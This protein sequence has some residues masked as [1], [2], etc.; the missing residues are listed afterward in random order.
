MDQERFL[1]ACEQIVGHASERDVIGRL[2]E[3]TLH[4]VIKQYVESDHTFHEVKLGAYYADVLRN[5]HVTEIQTRSLG[6]L[7]EKLAFF[8]KEHTVT[9]IYPIPAEKHLIW[10]DAETGET[11]EKRK[12]SKR[13]SFYDAGRELWY[14][15]ELLGH[16]R[17]TVHLMLIDM[18][19][20]RTR[21]KEKNKRR[22]SVRYDRIPLALREE[23]CLSTPSSYTA[24]LPDVL[25]G[26]F[27]AKDFRRV[28]K[29]GPKTAPA[30]LSVLLR[31][32]IVERTGKA[33]RAYLYKRAV[34]EDR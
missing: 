16:P 28:V 3:K 27:T 25:N 2:A 12:V 21:G 34:S 33:G 8:L 11:E 18:E 20:Y 19:E 10:M 4:A 14:L 15:S 30:L 6:R 9:V 26:E 5:G 1:L 17:L 29:G 22:G 7:R 24:L 31:L 32:G 23:L 13:G